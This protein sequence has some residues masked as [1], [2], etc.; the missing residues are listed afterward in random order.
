MLE[1]LKKR[2]EF[3]RVAGGG[4]KAVM[5]GLILQARDAAETDPEGVR[6]GFT[7]SRKVGGAVE[8]NRAK[9]RLRAVAEEVLPKRARPGRNYVLIGRAATLSRP[10]GALVQDLDEALR[11]I[12]GPGARRGARKATMARGGAAR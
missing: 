6:V 12:E 9:R 11:R 8:R 1:R 7:V 3:L 2:R 4:R 5:P 10:Y